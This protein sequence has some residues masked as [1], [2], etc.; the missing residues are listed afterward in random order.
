MM[1]DAVFNLRGIACPLLL[2][3]AV[4]LH[5]V[6]ALY[7]CSI[8]SAWEESIFWKVRGA[9]GLSFPIALASVLWA[10]QVADGKVHTAGKAAPRNQ[11]VVT[12]PQF[13]VRIHFASQGI[14][15]EVHAL[16]IKFALF[17]HVCLRCQIQESWRTLWKTSKR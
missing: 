6:V 12:L 10:A 1:V 2:V 13:E 9:D 8:A 17:V 11:L 14:W 4:F 7:F 15:W 5:L 3:D 16:F